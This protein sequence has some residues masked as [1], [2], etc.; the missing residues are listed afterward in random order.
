M[1]TP[2]CK[3]ATCEGR[4]VFHIEE[5]PSSRPVP[6]LLGP[7]LTHILFKCRELICNARHQWWTCRSHEIPP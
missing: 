2:T 1:T 4:E 7:C 3:K 6:A 5:P